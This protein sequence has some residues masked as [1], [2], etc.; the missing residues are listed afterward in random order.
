M[1][2]E[3]WPYHVL[4]VFTDR[5]LA[6]NQLAVFAEASTIPEGLLQ[7]LAKEIGFAETVF[8]YP[9]DHGGDARMRIFTPENEIPFAGHPT[10]GTAIVVSRHL[11]KN[12]VVLET[13]RGP[14]PVRIERGTGPASRGTMEQPIPSMAPYAHADALL[15]ALRVDRSI[16]PITRY[17]NGIPHVYAVFERE[18]DVAALRPDLAALARLA[19]DS[20]ES[21]VGFNVSAGTG[22][23][24]KT[25]MFAPADGVPEDAATGSAAGPLAL[26]LTRHG[27]VSWGSEIRVSQGVEIG[28]PS[29]LFA[30]ISGDADRIATIEVAGFALTVGGGWFDGDLLRASI[31]E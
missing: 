26:H 9:A 15:S 24:W 28:R 29:T 22:S 23:A 20:N 16:L 18:E 27:L 10:L 19:R 21:V 17:D 5:P 12:Q 7:P 13:G 1:T 14:V 4:D 3:R 31:A 25:R 11:G 2:D 6:V 8:L 30:R